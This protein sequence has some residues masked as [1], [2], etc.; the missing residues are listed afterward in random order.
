MGAKIITIPQTAK[1]FGGKKR[2][3]TMAYK[4]G[5]LL[6]VISKTLGHSKSNSDAKLPE[7]D[8]R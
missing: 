5:G 2:V 6:A 8:R 1:R 4:N 7:R 3:G